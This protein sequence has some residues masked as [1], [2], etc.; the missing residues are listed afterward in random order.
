MNINAGCCAGRSKCRQMVM[1]T[2]NPHPSKC[3]CGSRSTSYH[4]SVQL[5]MTF[6]KLRRKYRVSTTQCAARCAVTVKS[7]PVHAGKARAISKS[8][9]SE[10]SA[11]SKNLTKTK[12]SSYSPPLG[13]PRNNLNLSFKHTLLIL[14]DLPTL[15]RIMNISQSRLDDFC[16][17]CCRCSRGYGAIAF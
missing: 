8:H 6:Y 16:H 7:L 3:P 9:F 1:H 5:N 14:T 12:T 13:L 15:L 2:Y 11:Q 17:F 4:G 10:H